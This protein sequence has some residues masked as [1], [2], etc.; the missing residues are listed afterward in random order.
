MRQDFLGNPTSTE[1]D[2]TLRAVDEFID[3]YLAY[4]TRAEGIIQRG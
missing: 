1:C 4:E 3:G 2:A